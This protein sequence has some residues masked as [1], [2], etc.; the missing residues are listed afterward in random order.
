MHESSSI[1]ILTDI[2]TEQDHVYRG[3][4]Q[5]QQLHKTEHSRISTQYKQLIEDK[6]QWLSRALHTSYTYIV[7]SVYA[8]H[9]LS[10]VGNR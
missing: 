3:S 7:R 2:T 10:M 5:K 9:I 4:V 6:R 8:K 1:R